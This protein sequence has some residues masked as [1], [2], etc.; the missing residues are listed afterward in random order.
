MEEHHEPSL[1]RILQWE[2]AFGLLVAAFIVTSALCLLVSRIRGCF[3]PQPANLGRDI[4]FL[5]SGP[6]SAM[7][8]AAV[9]AMEA[10]RVFVSGGIDAEFPLVY[11]LRAPAAY[12]V[13]AFLC[14]VLGVAAFTLP[15]K[16]PA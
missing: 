13:V 15:A 11:G 14:F 9:Q 5:F 1:L 8:Y 2:G 7:L 10:A 16:S 4:A 12:C 6:V 3:R